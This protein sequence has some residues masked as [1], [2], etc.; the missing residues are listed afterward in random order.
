MESIL[1]KTLKKITEMQEKVAV[2]P[3]TSNSDEDDA[4]VKVQVDNSDERNLSYESEDIFSMFNRPI[5]SNLKVKVDVAIDE[6]IE[7]DD[8]SDAISESGE[9]TVYGQGSNPKPEDETYLNLLKKSSPKV[10]VK[11]KS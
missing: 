1:K 11:I 2:V 5:Y 10:K 6:D 4:K 9:D 7:E 8:Y 3:S